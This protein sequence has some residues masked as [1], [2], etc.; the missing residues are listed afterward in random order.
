MKK[1]LL[2]RVLLA[3]LLSGPVLVHAGILKDDL[4][5]ASETAGKGLE[6]VGEDADY[7][8]RSIV[9]G[10]GAIAVAPLRFLQDVFNGISQGA[11]NE[12]LSDH[13]N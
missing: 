3:L 6:P 5:E 9:Y 11:A 4:N 8:G 13:T 2:G 12:K 1:R 10:I 7:L